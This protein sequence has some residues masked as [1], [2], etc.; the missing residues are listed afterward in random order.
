VKSALPADAVSTPSCVDTDGALRQRHGMHSARSRDHVC[1]ASR[2]W[3]DQLAAMGE[4]IRAGL[5]RREQCIVIAKGAPMAT[6]AEALAR[7]G[8]ADVAA[9]RVTIVGAESA[10]LRGGAFEPERLLA[11]VEERT[12]EALHAGLTGTRLIG[13][14]TSIWDPC[15]DPA[16]VTE[17]EAKLDHWMADRPVSAMCMY[18]RTRMP[19]RVVRDMFTTHPL[20]LI[21]ATVCRNTHYLSSASVLSPDRWGAEVDELLA[22]V[23]ASALADGRILAHRR[24]LLAGQ[25]AERRS[26]ARELHDG[27]GQL[28]AAIQLGM[29]E[30]PINVD[31]LDALIGEALESVRSLA[32]ELRSAMLD[33]LGLAAALRAYVRRIVR[34]TELAVELR[35]CEAAVPPAAATTCFRIVQEAVLNIVRHAR[36]QRVV[37]DV[38]T[39]GGALTLTVEDDGVGFDPSRPGL[40][41][42]GMTERA[43]LAGGEIAIASAPGAGTTIRA[44]LPIGGGA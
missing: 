22:R 33:D 18:D 25:E 30:K 29:R 28:L 9:D 19:A 12:D 8:V 32:L 1:V 35:V 2:A 14:M 3:I 41:I 11:W 4:L 39:S 38:G 17:F 44:R 27:F 37:I 24:E 31:E 5:E 15:P 34:E 42:V 26:I 36:A 7:A 40:G 43:A 16:Q 21:D 6:V 10:E 13:E 23:R 20:V